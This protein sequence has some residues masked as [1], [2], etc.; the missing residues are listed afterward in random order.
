M[1]FSFGLILGFVLGVTSTYNLIQ[2]KLKIA[3]SLEN[4]KRLI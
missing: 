4:F 1:W 2:K 3:T